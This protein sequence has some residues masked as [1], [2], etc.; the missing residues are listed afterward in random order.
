MLN[1][2]DKLCREMAKDCTE[3]LIWF[4]LNPQNP[5]VLEHVENGST[6]VVYPERLH[7]RAGGGT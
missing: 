5:T 3:N 2:D 1:A 7:H 6:A 4:S